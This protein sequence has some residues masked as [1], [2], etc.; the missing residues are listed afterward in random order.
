VAIKP[1]IQ[2]PN[3]LLTTPCAK[4]GKVDDKTRQIVK[5]LLDT[6]LAAKNPEGAGLAAPQIGILKR[7]CIVREFFPDP[8]NLNPNNSLSREHVLIN[9]KIITASNTTE[10]HWEGCLSIPDTYGRVERA[11]KIKIMAQNDAGERITLRAGGFF[12]AI[13]QHEIDHLD[14]VL[15]TSKTIGKTMTER[16]LDEVFVSA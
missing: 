12:A 15:F 16:E 7:V 9:P 5:D 3:P 10:T 1:I 4:A 8:A 6:L 11:A 13:I 14:G 2:V